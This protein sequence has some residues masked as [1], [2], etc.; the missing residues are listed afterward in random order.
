[1]TSTFQ[2]KAHSS[3]PPR[4]F[5]IPALVPLTGSLAGGPHHS[6]SSPSRPYPTKTS[7]HSHRTGAPKRQRRRYRLGLLL[8]PPPGHPTSSFLPPSSLTTPPRPPRGSPSLTPLKAR[9]PPKPYLGNPFTPRGPPTAPLAMSL[10]IHEGESAGG[11]RRVVV[12]QV[13]DA[14]LLARHGAD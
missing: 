3:K 2:A 7:T 13:F 4:S 11:R 10:E 5:L 12:D 8:P 6:S 14:Q 1:M 9:A